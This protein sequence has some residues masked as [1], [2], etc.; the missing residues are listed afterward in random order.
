MDSQA[1]ENIALVIG[2]I[3]AVSLALTQAMGGLVMYLVEAI[4]QTGK[5]R[6][7]YSGI[8]AVVVGV[9][10]GM[11]LA[12][13]ADGMAAEPYG[14]GTMLLLGAFAGA[15]MA[16]GAV[17][18]YK[19]SGDVNTTGAFSEGMAAGELAASTNPFTPLPQ[20]FGQGYAAGLSAAQPASLV[21]FEGPRSAPDEIDE[22]VGF[23]ASLKAEREAAFLAS[24]GELDKVQDLSPDEV[25]SVEAANA[26]VAWPEPITEDEA[27][28]ASASNASPVL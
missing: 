5:V 14:L 16:A 2:I 24:V 6:D 19:A 17:K 4:K 11:G 9:L 27:A 25:A 23:L 12:G 20:D 8:V 3:V 26:E 22:A 1:A 10:L 7:G 21:S 18:T 28:K 13:L 15:L